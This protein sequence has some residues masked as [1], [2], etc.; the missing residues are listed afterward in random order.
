[1]IV[2]AII[3]ILVAIS[4]PAY[5]NYVI[6]SEVAEGLSLADSWKVA[7]GEFF[8]NYGSFPSGYTATG[9]SENIAM[10][11]ASSG[12]YVSS[13]VV[14]QGGQILIT[15][16]GPAANVNL[17]QSGANVL[18]LQAGV[19]PND[20]LVWFCGTATS[21]QISLSVLPEGTSTTIPNPYLPSACHN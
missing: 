14:G 6:R 1:M 7:V 8:A 21:G 3:G 5:Q 10:P 2:I 19:N 4:I 13:I 18:S 15:Y 20:E 11:A 12:K 16:A 17:S 9:D